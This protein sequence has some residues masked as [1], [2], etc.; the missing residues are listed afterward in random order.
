[1][2]PTE[3]L[4]DLCPLEA[5]APPDCS[6][7]HIQHTGM[8]QSW[9]TESSLINCRRF[10]TW[11]ASF[12]HKIINFAEKSLI[13]GQLVAPGPYFEYLVPLLR[14]IDALTK[15]NMKFKNVTR[16]KITPFYIKVGHLK[17]GSHGPAEFSCFNSYKIHIGLNWLFFFVFFFTWMVFSFVL[18]CK[19]IVKC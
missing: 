10:H 19:N 11:L 14:L 7:P 18:K 3:W 5:P 8:A 16:F 9:T 17:E 2:W 15:T 6:D 1:M 4:K 12:N 13:Q